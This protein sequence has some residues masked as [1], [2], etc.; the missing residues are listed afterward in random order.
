M[1]LGYVEYNPFGGRGPGWE[2]AGSTRTV[3][4]AGHSLVRGIYR[5]TNPG[6][7]IRG[8][9]VGLAGDVEAVEGAAGRSCPNV[10]DDGTGGCGWRGANRSR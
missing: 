7:S 3:Q 9:A 6:G 1:P 4:R 5:L 10:S 8:E 2:A